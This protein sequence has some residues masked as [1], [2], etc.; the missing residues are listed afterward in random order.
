MTTVAV[1]GAGGKLGRHVLRVLAKR[2]MAVRALCHRTPIAGENVKSI[3]GS[4]TDAEAVREVVRGAELVVQMATTKE[5]PE[6][7]FD[8][9][10][11]GTFNILEACRGARI[12]QF[13]LFGGDAAMGIWFYPQPIPIDENHPLMAYPGYYAFSK[14]MEE[15]MANQYAIQYGVPV[16]ILRSSWVFEGADLLNHF[17]LLKNVNPAEPGHGFGEVSEAILDLVRARKER[18]PIL[19][20]GQGVPLYRHIVHIDDV[21]QAF[22]KML[23]EPAAF[24]QSFNI[25]GPSPFN[26]RVAANYLSAKLG[27]PTV[28]IPCPTYHAF[29]INISRARTLLGYAPEN[30]FFRMADRAI[31]EAM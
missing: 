7:F 21:M 2:G 19:T 10:V 13:L 6:T 29:E 23:D 12:R 17:S 26:Y 28:E 30:D 9:S 15:V 27:I 24:G 16:T 31:E 14:V 1:F 3:P 22:D 25:A 5:D 4:I 20:D 18:I 11:R 8:V